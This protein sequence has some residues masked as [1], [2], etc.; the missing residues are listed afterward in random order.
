[1]HLIALALL[2]AFLPPVVAHAEDTSGASPVAATPEPF[3][4]LTVAEVAKKLGEKKVYVYDN[5]GE[6][7]YAAGHIPGAKWLHP[8]EYESIALPADRSATLIFYCANE[9]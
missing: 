8:L 9:H 7:M 3:G 6:K 1:M 4:R 2:A 5:N